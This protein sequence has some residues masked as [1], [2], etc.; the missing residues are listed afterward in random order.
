MVFIMGAKSAWNEDHIL[1]RL[2]PNI[3]E[4]VLEHV[5]R[6]AIDVIPMLNTR[7]PGFVSAILR[8]LRPQLY[9]QV[10]QH[11]QSPLRNV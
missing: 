4:K 5:H 3:R 8:H 1:S 7:P 10:V 6:D 11:A 9:M 2:P